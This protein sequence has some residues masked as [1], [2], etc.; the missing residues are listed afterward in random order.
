MGMAGPRRLQQGKG[1][2]KIITSMSL[3]K[4]VQLNKAEQA[5]KRT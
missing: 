4:D 5:W 2:R 3:G 1:P